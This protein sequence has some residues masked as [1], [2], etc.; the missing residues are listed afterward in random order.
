VSDEIQK[1]SYFEKMERLK[2]K[3]INAHNKA[4]INDKP[5]PKKAL[6]YEVIHWTDG[7]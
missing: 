4:K 3:I 2:S 5:D 6:E 7:I 1:W